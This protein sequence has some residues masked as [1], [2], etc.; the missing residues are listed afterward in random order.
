MNSIFDFRAKNYD[1]WF[2]KNAS[3]YQSELNALKRFIHEG[4][5]VEIG[6]GTGRFAEPLGIHTGIDPSMPMLSIARKRGIQAIRGVAESLPIDNNSF[7]AA[8]IMTTLCFVN[9]PL[10]ALLEAKRVVRKYGSVVI[11][12]IDLESHVGSEYLK[13]VKNSPFYQGARFYSANEIIDLLASI[14]MVDI[15]TC[16]TIFSEPELMTA[17]DPVHEGH[18]DGLFVTIRARVESPKLNV[19]MSKCFKE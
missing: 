6:V 1:R 19:Q 2:D 16:Q 7:D 4:N 3:A 13:K 10:V 9:D 12:T 17:P 8:L 15:I 5:N 18:G 11:G 14:E